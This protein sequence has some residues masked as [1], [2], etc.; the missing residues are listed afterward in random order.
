[1][2]PSKKCYDLIKSEE[3]LKTKAYLCPANVPTIGYGSTA[4]TNGKPILL[5]DQITLS[6]AEDLL[7]WEVNKKA[8]SVDRLTVRCGLSQNQ[9]DALVSF[10]FN[11]GVGAFERSTL[12]KKIIANPN[13]PD[14]AVQFARWNKGGGKVLNG[15]VK[16]R[17]K[18]S[19][20]YFSK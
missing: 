18:E 12:L 7:Q 19:D 6:Q 10:A 11:V 4:Y 1:M 15:L 2:T 3:G 13:D 14:I 16:R 17:K 5:G 20:L 9:F 8:V